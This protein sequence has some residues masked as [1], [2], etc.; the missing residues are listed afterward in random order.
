MNLEIHHLVYGFITLAPV[1]GLVYKFMS[2][3]AEVA[4]WRG[5]VETKLEQAEEDR[6]IIHLRIDER[7]NKLDEMAKCL[8]SLTSKVD[9]LIDR[10]ERK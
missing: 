5:V 4:K 10:E 7:D 8:K 2:D 1:I 9:I 6:K 3:K